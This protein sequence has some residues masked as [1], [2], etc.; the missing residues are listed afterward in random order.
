[1]STSRARLIAS[2][3]APAPAAHF[4]FRAKSSTLPASLQRMARP[5]SA[6][7]SITVRAAGKSLVTPRTSLATS[8]MSRSEFGA[9][10]RPAPVATTRSTSSLLTPASSKAAAY[11]RSAASRLSN[12]ARIMALPTTAP[13]RATTTLIVLAPMSI[14][15]VVICSSNRSLLERE[16]CPLSLL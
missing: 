15:A 14:P 4:S 5:S 7:T 6:P 3:N 2:V 9:W 8:E 11:A 1:M 12:P 10:L 16:R 13:S